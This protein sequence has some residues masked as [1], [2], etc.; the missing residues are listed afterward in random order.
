VVASWRTRARIAARPAMLRNDPVRA[1]PRLC[2]DPTL[3]PNILR[4]VRRNPSSDEGGEGDSSFGDGGWPSSRPFS[5]KSE[6]HLW[7]TLDTGGGC[8]A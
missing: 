4:P 7:W 5:A 3:P 2:K 1:M 6:T 8:G